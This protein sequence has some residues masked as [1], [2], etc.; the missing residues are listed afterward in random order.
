MEERFLQLSRAMLRMQ[1]AL[2]GVVTPELR[3]VTVDIDSNEK[4]LFFGFFYD[5]E[6]KSEFYDLAQ[7][8]CSKAAANFPQ[9]S[10]RET[11]VRIDFPQKIPFRGRYAYLRKEE[12]CK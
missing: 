10:L 9:Y 12:I 4:I 2:L 8:A 5:G 6:L 1:E 7:M 11:I 3:S